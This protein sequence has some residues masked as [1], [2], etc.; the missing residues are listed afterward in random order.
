[1]NKAKKDKKPKAGKVTR[2][3]PEG[4]QRI[5]AL[6]LSLNSTGWSLCDVI[7]GEVTWGTIENTDKLSGIARLVAI[8]DRIAELL[9]RDPSARTVVAIENFAFGKGE[10]ANEIGMLHGVVRL[11][12]HNR[13]LYCLLAAP[14]QIK[15]WVTGK[16]FAEKSLIIKYIDKRYGYDCDQEDA[17]D[18]LGLMTMTRAFVG[19]HPGA[20]VSFQKEVLDALMAS[21]VSI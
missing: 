5:L 16:S 4:T 7:G 17:A 14:T 3:V 20:L 1:M 10:K 21:T 8:R 11:E 12:I 15:K 2:L 13:G 19:Q 9:D 6:D 18:A